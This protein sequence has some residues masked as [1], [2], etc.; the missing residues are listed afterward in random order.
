MKVFVAS[1][2]FQ[3]CWFAAVLGTYQW[4]WFT[5]FLTLLTVAYCVL[6]DANSL[7]RIAVVTI[8]GLVVDS[9]NQQFSLLIFQPDWLP[10]WLLCLWVV[11]AWYACQLKS[12]LHRFP[13]TYVSI[14]GG[15][16]GVASYYA[17]YKLQAVEFG[18]SVSF[19][20]MILFMEWCAVMVLIL[21]V[22]GNEK[23]AGK[24]GQESD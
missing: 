22:Y 16:G 3:I 1:I 2:W 11:F 12:V 8:I 9:L 7:K 21:K 19:T 5:V 13:K 23:L 20:V 15:V 24:L 17:G 10:V 14:V 6:S 18:Y 4:Q